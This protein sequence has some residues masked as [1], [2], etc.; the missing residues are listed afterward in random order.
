MSAMDMTKQQAIGLLGGSVTSAA[1]ELGVTRQAVEKWPDVLP[2]R[3][4][5]RVRG[6]WARKNVPQLMPSA[7]DTATTE[8]R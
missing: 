7:T 8:A 6:A 4:A 2:D 3:I 1:A 5:D